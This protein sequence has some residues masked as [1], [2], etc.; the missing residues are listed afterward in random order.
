MLFMDIVTWD[1][2]I[3]MKFMSE[4]EIMFPRDE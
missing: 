4:H 3:C 2:D 1:S